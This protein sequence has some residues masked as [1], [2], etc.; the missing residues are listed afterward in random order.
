MPVWPAAGLNIAGRPGHPP[1]MDQTRRAARRQRNA[2]ERETSYPLMTFLETT[3]VRQGTSNMY[4]ERVLDFLYFVKE[5]DLSFASDAAI[6]Q[7]FAKYFNAAYL[8][9]NHVTLGRQTLAGFLHLFPSYGRHGPSNLPRTHRA[10]R[11]WERDDR[12]T[13]EIPLLWEMDCAMALVCG[14]EGEYGVGVYILVLFD[15]YARPMEMLRLRIRDVVFPNSKYPFAAVRLNPYDLQRPSKTGAYDEYV[16]LSGKR[17]VEASKA[18][19]WYVNHRV[20]VQGALLEDPVFDFSYNHM[21]TVM[22]RA[23]RRCGTRVTA[24]ECRHGG[25]SDDA[26]HDVGQP[27]VKRRGR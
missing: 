10:L 23:G 7:S 11:A 16:P 14:A 5:K 26:A 17:R 21:N 24:Y 27:E 18:L 19:V 15:T 2:A 8:G 3:R 6:D 1:T 9:G 12:S 4:E 22:Q 13:S 20:N 25:A